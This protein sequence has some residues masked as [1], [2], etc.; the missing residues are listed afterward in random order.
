MTIIVSLLSAGFKFLVQPEDLTAFVASWP[1]AA[2]AIAE[3]FSILATTF[4]V[5]SIFVTM[6]HGIYFMIEKNRQP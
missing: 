1:L 5:V 4:V 6:L 2:I 3:C